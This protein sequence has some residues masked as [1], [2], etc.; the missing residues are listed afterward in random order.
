MLIDLCRL[1]A[2]HTC[3]RPGFVNLHLVQ[4]HVLPPPPPALVVAG[5]TLL[6]SE[7]TYRSAKKTSMAKSWTSTRRSFPEPE[8]RPSTYSRKLAYRSPPIIVEMGPLYL[9]L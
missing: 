5:Q 8:E 1:Q 3:A 7:A 2:V 4:L 6:L 9:P